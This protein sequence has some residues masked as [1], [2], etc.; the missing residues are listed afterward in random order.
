M[1]RT[2]FLA[3]IVGAASFLTA[4]SGAVSAV[5]L[6]PPVVDGPANQ[7]LPFSSGSYLVWTQNE[8]GAR[9]D[10]NAFIRP[11]GGGPKTQINARGDGFTGSFDLGTDTMIYQQAQRQRSDLFLYDAVAGTRTGLP[12]R[13]N[14]KHWEWAPRLSGT[15]ILF[16]RDVGR[17][18]RLLLYDRSTRTIVAVLA[19]VDRRRVYLTSGG[20]GDEYATWT[21]CDAKSCIAR[22]HRISTGRTRAIPGPGVRPQYAPVVDEATSTTYWVTSG[23]GCGESVNIWRA[24]VADLNDRTKVTSFPNRID[25]GLTIALAPNLDT[26]GTDLW[27][28]RV[29]CREQQE[30]VWGLRGVQP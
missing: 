30:D 5:P 4:W 20:V 10:Y 15:H 13:I 19:D 26:L 12:S 16:A 11:I 22:V 24:P 21:T 9:N 7:T 2:R 27:F 29:D 8:P 18:T 17:R 23:F 1:S 6:H 25:T 14:S 3:S 28:T